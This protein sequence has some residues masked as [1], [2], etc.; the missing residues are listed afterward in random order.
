MAAQCE[1]IFYFVL[2]LLQRVVFD[3]KKKGAMAP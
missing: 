1:I 3:T 2:F